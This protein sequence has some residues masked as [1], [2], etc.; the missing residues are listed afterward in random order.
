V[1]YLIVYL[2]LLQLYVYVLSVSHEQLSYLLN[3]LLF[4]YCGVDQGSFEYPT[5]GGITSFGP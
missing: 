2:S 3:I 4:A 1:E 5:W